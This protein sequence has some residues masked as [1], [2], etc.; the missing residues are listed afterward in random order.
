MDKKTRPIYMLPTRDSL[1]TQRHTQ[2][3]SEG[4]KTI[5]HATNKEK[6]AE[7]AVLLSDKIEFKTKKVTRDKEGHYI[8]IKGAVQQEDITII[9]IYAPN[10]QYRSTNICETNT[11]RIKGGNRMQSIH[12]RRLQHTTHSKGQIHQTENK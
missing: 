6:K 11:N 1:Q 4:W 12:F 5:F 10:T 2:T 3:K 9:N 7:V 8:M